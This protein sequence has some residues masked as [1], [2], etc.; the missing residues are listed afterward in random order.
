RDQLGVGLRPVDLHRLDLDVP[1]AEVFQLLGQLV[2]LLALLADDHA[3]AG[4]VDVDDHLLARP[5]DLDLGDAGVAVAALDEPA[6]LLVL[7]QQ[8]AEVLLAGVP[9]AQP[10]G[11][12]A[13][14]EAR[15]PN[16]LTHNV[17]RSPRS[18]TG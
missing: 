5:L 7:D 4:G 18:D 10:V 17:P 2:D 3:D 16:L 15:R 12:D 9:L 14:A 1:V 6:D 8:L 11:H 13:G